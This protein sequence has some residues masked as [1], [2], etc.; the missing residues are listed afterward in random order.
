MALSM[1]LGMTIGVR[2]TMW[3]MAGELVGVALVT[4][5]AVLGVA[6]LM[7]QAPNIFIAFQLIGGA[8]LLWLGW[9]M[10]QSKG[11]LAIPEQNENKEY[12]RWGLIHQG[13]VTAVANPKGWAFWVVFMASFI[14]ADQPLAAQLLV[15]M[16][17]QLLLEWLA[18]MLYASGGS[19]LRR[20]LSKKH[21]VQRLNRIAGTLMMGVGIWLASGAF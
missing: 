2:R 20:W 21:S 3:M 12:S 18:L 6:T 4:L 10:W 19:G 11:S 7:L 13:F 5:C 8:Y 1:S 15:L 16:A 9:Q 17:I 14:D